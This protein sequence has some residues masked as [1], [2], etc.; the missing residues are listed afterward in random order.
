MSTGAAVSVASMAAAAL[1]LA[2]ASVIRPRA[3]AFVDL[4][5]V[6]LNDDEQ[7]MRGLTERDFEIREEGQLLPVLTAQ[8]V[9]TATFPRTIVVILDDIGVV[10]GTVNMQ[11]MA[12]AFLQPANEN[13]HVS[14]LRLSHR[15]DEPTGH[16][17]DALARIDEYIAGAYPYAGRETIQNW[18]RLVTKISRQV[19]PLDGRK[20]I[21]SIGSPTIFDVIEPQDRTKSLIWPQWV[22]AL[23]AASR[24]NV[25][26]YVVD[27]GGVATTRRLSA[28][29]LVEKTGGQVFATNNFQRVADRIWSDAGHYYIVS[30]VPATDERELHAVD[31]RVTKRGAHVR[32]RRARGN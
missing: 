20:M 2:S 17:S 16:M 1:I 31:L 10:A 13:D 32:W 23:T 26:V 30:Y 8:E 5:A 22:E 12:L 6:V 4:D 25:S 18:L 11:R 14:L 3:A 28:D 21:V 7:P 24:S 19:E 9:T 27:P 29:G 15:D